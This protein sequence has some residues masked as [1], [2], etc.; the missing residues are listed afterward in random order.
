[1]GTFM[2]IISGLSRLLYEERPR[3]QCVIGLYPTFCTVEGSLHLV[4]AA[5]FSLQKKNNH[6]IV[7]TERKWLAQSHPISWYGWGWNK[8]GFFLLQD[9]NHYII[10][11][12][13]ESNRF[14]QGNPIPVSFCNSKEIELWNCN[15]FC[16]KLIKLDT[17]WIHKLV[18][19]D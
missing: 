8:A 2:V 18:T 13:L 3:W 15:V 4:L 14:L 1:M 19:S 12:S 7:W 11:F 5:Y 10:Q 6:M 17:A 9:L 16:H